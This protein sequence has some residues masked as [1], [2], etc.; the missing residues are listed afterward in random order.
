MSAF[1]RS[2]TDLWFILAGLFTAEVVIVLYAGKAS[3]SP[4]V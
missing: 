3:S 1:V 2:C 4:E